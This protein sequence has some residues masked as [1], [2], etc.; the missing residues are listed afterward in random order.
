PRPC[1]ESKQTSCWRMPMKDVDAPV[2]PVRE[3]FVATRKELC[4]ALIERD[5]EVDLALSALI[6]HEHLLLVGPPGCGKS[7][8]L[9]SLM[10]W[11][12]GRRFTCLMTKYTAPEELFGPISVRGLKEDCYR[13]VT[14]GRMPEAHLVYLDE[15]MKASS[16]IL[17]TLLRILNERVFEN[18]DGSL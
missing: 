4:E 13:R 6:A 5:G 18:G 3:K 15:V 10:G 7:L 17:N 8:L 9:D 14:T 2:L 11:T 1:T 16:A 12:S